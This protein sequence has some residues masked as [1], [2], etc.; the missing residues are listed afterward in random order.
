M[1]RLGPA[2][3]NELPQSSLVYNV[4][5]RAPL[6]EPQLV[7][8]G[9]L[10]RRTGTEPRNVNKICL[11][12]DREGSDETSQPML[13]RNPKDPRV[14]SITSNLPPLQKVGSLP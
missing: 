14:I 13:S 4:H 12:S 8:L 1:L 7:P 2:E 11:W 10:F 9:F 3:P 5:L 6:K